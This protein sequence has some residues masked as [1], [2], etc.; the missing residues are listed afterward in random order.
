VAQADTSVQIWSVQVWAEVSGVT[1]TARPF[2]SQADPDAPSR[3]RAA[4]QLSGAI[5]APDV[6]SG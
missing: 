2:V 5:H 6:S 3:P 1:A 4:D